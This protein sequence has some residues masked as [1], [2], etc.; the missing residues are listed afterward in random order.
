[1]RGPVLAALALGAAAVW[2]FLEVADEVL[3]GEIDALDRRILLAFRGADGAPLGPGW[4]QEMLRDFT[5]LGGTGVLVFVTLAAVG[6]L[7]LD[8]KR[9]AALT[10]LLAVVGGQALSTVLKLG[11]DRDR[12]D[13]VP[14]GMQVYTASFP[15]GHAMMAAV[16][17]LTL[18]ALLAGVHASWRAKAYFLGV[19]ILITLVVG[20]SRVYLGV[21]W[22]SDV[23]AGWAVGAAWACLC[24]AV[25]RALQREG[26]VEPENG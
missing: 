12:P 6:F 13:L 10:V 1:M 19:A 20:T 24:W 26:K 3:E 22:P 21:H 15:S 16:T 4:L 9:H 5:A 8:R 7:L 2:G 17:W 14:H 18:G 11:F 23:L 25:M